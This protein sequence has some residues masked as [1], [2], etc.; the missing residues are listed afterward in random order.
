MKYHQRK[1]TRVSDRVTPLK[2]EQA[3]LDLL[4]MSISCI[5]FLRGFFTDKHFKDD[6][7]EI[8]NNRETK[9]NNSKKESI[10]IKR[11]AYGISN[12]SDMIL[13]WI[14]ISI[15]D[16][17]HKK[18]LKSVNLS[19]ILDEKKPTEVFESYSFDINY[20]FQDS[21][22]I[23]NE[24]SISP[25]EMT[26]FQIFKLL[27]RFII[28]TQSL[29]A[30]PPKRFLLMRILCYDNCPV[31]YY[32]DYFTNCTNEKSATM[33][34][35][36]SIYN[37]L[38]APCGEVNSIHH[39]V[40]TSLLSLSTLGEKKYTENES[41]VE[42]DPFEIFGSHIITSEINS[43]VSQISK[44][45]YQMVKTHNIEMHDGLTQIPENLYADNQTY[46]ENIECSCKSHIYIPYSPI[47]QCIKCFRNMHKICFSV[48]SGT[49]D[50]I[51]NYCHDYDSN[52]NINSF[53]ILFNIRKLI[54]YLQSNKYDTLKSVTNTALLLGYTADDLN[55]SKSI[56]SSIIKSFTILIYEGIISL[57]LNKAFSHK[58]FKV[59]VNGLLNNDAVVKKGR[60][61]ISF[62][63]KNNQSIIDKYIDPNREPIKEI[64]FILNSLSNDQ[65]YEHK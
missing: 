8:Q 44:D 11:L 40:S 39:L 48:N 16:A 13:N 46:N 19:I 63:N 7:F 28:I 43:E 4:I 65:Q 61:F 5:A 14:Q 17:L 3:I 22:T 2:S 18:Y 59:D 64:E 42:V 62:I 31:D 35:P 55:S 23:N 1:R 36:L 60:Y 34:I 47:V 49:E 29:P 54:A 57:K 12:D 45:L 15:H 37:D 58:A 10:K 41:V 50:F 24:M 25:N 9:N 6:V 30:L 32:P 33:K 51:C 21:I 27:K 52:F 53:L 26:K 56:I 38:I 20:D